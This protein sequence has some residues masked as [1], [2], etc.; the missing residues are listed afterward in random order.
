MAVIV[1][2]TTVTRQ[3]QH[4]AQRSSHQKQQEGNCADISSRA[5]RDN[6]GS[7][8]K[9][10]KDTASEKPLQEK[11]THD[12]CRRHTTTTLPTHKCSQL[13]T[14]SQNF[15]SFSDSLAWRAFTLHIETSAPKYDQQ[16]FAADIHH[17]LRHRI[18]SRPN[19]IVTRRSTCV[20][21]GLLLL[22]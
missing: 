2:T 20:S 13:L 3:S 4:G 7:M 22:E 8:G 15:F 19:C 16:P 6:D 14:A 21:P 12:M 1:L 18:H 9:Y 17:N 10:Q 5:L 11:Q